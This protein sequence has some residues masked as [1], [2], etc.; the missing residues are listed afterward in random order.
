MQEPFNAT[1]AVLMNPVECLTTDKWQALRE[2]TLVLKPF[3]AVMTEIS[4]EMSV[5]ASKIIMLS[6]GLVAAC[7]KIQPSLTDDVSKALMTKLLEGMHKRF[8][9]IE[10]NNLLA[11]ATFLDPRFKKRGFA[12][13]SCYNS[14]KENVKENITAVISR[15][16]GASHSEAAYLEAQGVETQRSEISQSS[17]SDVEDLIWGE[18][19]QTVGV[20]VRNPQVS[21]MSLVRQFVEE[22]NIGRQADPLAWWRA[23]CASIP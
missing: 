21:A 13:E 7:H 6:R 1:I 16:L 22:L 8:G 14:V 5:T 4:A 18:F 11:S 12:T 15:Q 9:G 10:S 3:D 2:I 23:Q 20:E 19:D 17:F